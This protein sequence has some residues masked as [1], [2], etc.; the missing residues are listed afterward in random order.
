M[1]DERT[2]SVLA[3]RLTDDDDVR[4][5]ARQLLRYQIAGHIVHGGTAYSQ[6]SALAFEE[7]LEIEHPPVVDAGVWRSQPPLVRIAFK[8]REGEALLLRRNYKFTDESRP[9]GFDPRYECDRRDQCR[10]THHI[11]IFPLPAVARSRRKHS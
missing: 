11:V 1:D 8:A 5:S 4:Q 6:L 2:R 10:G 7:H 3:P 9:F